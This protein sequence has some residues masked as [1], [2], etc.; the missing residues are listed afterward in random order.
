MKSGGSN[1]REATDISVAQA[2]ETNM[3]TKV[4]LIGGV[5][6]ATLLAG[7]WAL[8]QSQGHDHGG[9][10]PAGRQGGQMGR[11]M[12]GQMGQGMHGQ[13]GQGR[14]GQM[15]QGQ[16]QGMRGQMGPGM[17]GGP[18][19]TFFDPARI[20]TL[21]AELGITAAQEPAWTKYT[22]AV[23]DAA[24]AA[25]TARADVDPDTVSKMTPADRFAFVSKMREQR[26]TQF[27][28]VK[29]AADEL[30][31]TLDDTQKA[32]ARETLPGLAFG[33]GPTR[34]AM[35]GSQHQH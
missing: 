10:G 5:A 29:T 20:D 6:A 28:T 14:H 15:G 17:R 25:Q 11:G 4:L 3:K 13:M 8:A 16:H 12:H 23:T 31:A 19:Q 22:K 32:K 35:A 27:D 30:L 1:D 24:A 7:G 9:A 2:L 33:P 26:Q 21:K 34:G 18:G